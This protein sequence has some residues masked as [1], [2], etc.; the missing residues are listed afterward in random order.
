MIEQEKQ[1]QMS[2]VSD[3]PTAESEETI[4]ARRIEKN[5]AEAKKMARHNHLVEDVIEVYKKIL[6]EEHDNREA[7]M[8]I[9]S[10]MFRV[11]DFG[12]AVTVLRQ[13]LENC[14]E[15]GT[16]RA[17]L[18]R[19]LWRSDKDKRQEAKAYMKEALELG[20]P[21]R[22]GWVEIAETAACVGDADALEIA[23]EQAEAAP[24]DEAWDDFDFSKICLDTQNIYRG[25]EVG[26]RAAAR[27]P[28]EPAI[29]MR[30]CSLYSA[31]GEIE[32]CVACAL[33]A[34]ELKPVASTIEPLIFISLFAPNMDGAAVSKWVKDWN[35]MAQRPM[36][37]IGHKIRPNRGKR[38]LRIG[39]VG[40]DFRH[41][42][43]GMAFAPIFNGWNVEKF[44][45]FAYSVAPD[46]DMGTE[47]FRHVMYAWRD[48]PHLSD[49]QL[50]LQIRMDRIDILV[51]LSAHTAGGRMGV[52]MHKP[53]P[54]QLSWNNVNGLSEMD[55]LITDAIQV[56]VGTEDQQLE[57]PWRLDCVAMPFLPAEDFPAPIVLD[58]DQP[59]ERP[60]AFGFYNN[61]IKI[62]EKL[63]DIMAQILIQAPESQ[64]ICK[65]F[66]LTDAEVQKQLRARFV[67]RN[68]DTERLILLPKS[69]R[70]KHLQSY[71]LL[72][73]ALDPFPGNGGVTSWE[74]L[75]MGV[76]LICLRGDRPNG[77]MSASILHTL[78]LDWLIA[79][80][81]QEYVDLAVRLAT[82][83]DLHYRAHTE[84]LNAVKEAPILQT[85]YYAG[86]IEE[87]Y[88]EIW[89]L[90]CAEQ[91]K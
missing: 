49:Q 50:A 13:A 24:S 75:I 61:L 77:R 86:K 19:A 68:I 41:H 1:D 53:A 14:P 36:I 2:L 59:K 38:K 57:K 21:D 34:I 9:G 83:P 78:G 76:P 16:F 44:E 64:L 81:T 66:S 72:D 48:A 70:M 39:Y 5:R 35:M 91:E 69:S 45:V 82:D 79:E 20:S 6:F 23:F 46:T 30:L 29:L 33:K 43:M 71:H 85:G 88:Q 28:D 63:L 4:K 51:D 67:S 62:N 56:P 52:F 37:P 73:L 74:T 54:I 65:F 84:I 7:L 11:H 15:D 42:S 10:L 58:K 8:G 90:W 32:K 3:L 40:A 60:F 18:A 47:S 25:I 89:S 17:M 22:K 27:A 26:K 55:W 80:T 12:A 31:A 87:A